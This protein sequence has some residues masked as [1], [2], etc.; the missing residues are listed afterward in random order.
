MHLDLKIT[1]RERERERDWCGVGFKVSR[2]I[3]PEH[4]LKLYYDI[5]KIHD[6][7]QT[8]RQKIDKS[9]KEKEKKREIENFVT[10]GKTP[11][12]ACTT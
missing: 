12:T 7:P 1:A 5:L 11:S 10:E 2:P 3:T 8:T 4:E 6:T 9:G